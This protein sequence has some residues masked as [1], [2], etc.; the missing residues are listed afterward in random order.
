MSN[1]EFLVNVESYCSAL[2]S[3]DNSIRQQGEKSLKALMTISQPYDM[4]F[5]VLKE[6][7][8]TWA[9]FYMLLGIRDASIKEWAILEPQRKLMIVDTLY[10]YILTLNQMSFVNSATRNQSY[11]TIAVICKRSWLD[12]E[13]YQQGIEMNQLIMERVYQCVDSNDFS[14][15]EAAIQM[16]HQMITEFSNKTNAAK[17]QLSWEY[18]L[19]CLMSFQSL[20]LQPLFRKVMTIVGQLQQVQMNS[21]TLQMLNITLKIFLDILEW[22][23]AEKDFSSLAFISSFS[24]A[25]HSLKP[26]EEWSA[27]FIQKQ[28]D[29]SYRSPVLELV[30]SLY[31][32]FIQLDKIP[33]LLR[34]SLGQ[35]VSL[36]GP[37]VKNI[38]DKN[39]YFSVY[40][41]KFIVVLEKSIQTLNWTEM[42]D[43]AYCIHRLCMNFRFSGFLQMNQPQLL[44]TFLQLIARFVFAALDLMKSTMSSGEEDL[45]SE[46]ELDCLDIVLKGWVALIVDLDSILAKQRQNQFEHFDQ[47]HPVFKQC[48]NEIYQKYIQTRLELSR[49][50]LSKYDQLEPDNDDNNDLN[51]DKNKYNAQLKSV[52]YI[53]R[54]NPT[55]SMDILQNEINKTVQTLKERVGDA[56]CF[57][58]LHWLIIFS[59][60]IVFDSDND[61]LSPIP[62]NVEEESLQQFKV[63]NGQ[64]D[65]I[66]DL[67]NAIIK[68]SMEYE[69]PLLKNNNIDK[70]S[71]LVSKTLVWFFAGWSLVYL[72]PS[73]TLNTQVSPKLLDSFATESNVKQICDFFIQKILWNLRFW[74]AV[75]QDVL[76][77]TCKLYYNLSLNR[78]LIQPMTASP[79]WSMLFYQK[80][81]FFDKLAPEIQYLLHRATVNILYKLPTITEIQTAFKEFT[82][83]LCKNLDSVLSHQNFQSIA[84]EAYVKENLYLILEKLRGVLGVQIDNLDFFSD[85]DKDPSLNLSF[86]LFMKYA[87]SFVAMLSI[88]NH[89]NDII[90]IILTLFSNF[91]KSQ[92][93]T[94]HERAKSA[95][96][97]LINLFQTISKITNSSAGT[98][99]KEYYNRIKVLIKILYNIITYCD[100]QNEYPRLISST[101]FNGITIVTPCLTNKYNLLQYPK[102]ARNYFMVLTFIFN[103]DDISE[104][105]NF[106]VEISNSIFRLVDS[107]LLHHDTEIVKGCFECISGLTKFGKNLQQHKIEFD[108]SILTQYI[109]S[110]INFLLMNEFNIDELLPT[111]SETLFD[112]IISNQQ[113]FKSKVIELI[114]V[115]EASIQQRIIQTFE[116]LSIGDGGRKSKDAFLKQVQNLLLIVKPLLKKQ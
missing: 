96:Q 52:S 60:H 17:I 69:E 107:G 87:N 71:P 46:I 103:S 82:S 86:D 102:L 93:S 24:N 34:T 113:G 53:G 37:V 9:H 22:G 89:N 6:S 61:R 36:T 85:N 19:K 29:G 15:M 54:I 84:Q 104:I 76:K 33:S 18:H 83:G 47:L 8:S 81:Q 77:E 21:L 105:K 13:K 51:E 4:F 39:G 57:E 48:S 98:D 92:I 43:L 11:N 111:A 59:G 42:Q 109:G 88:Y 3:N 26:T 12:S 91:T 49:M 14:Q 58:T 114:T 79:S 95:F 50:E 25:Q 97:C 106:P 32:Q 41:S 101:V 16:I 31:N 23:F 40:I 62:N 110:V 75:D 68:Y 28:Q 55:I 63:T 99:N 72:I 74:G 2:V 56:Q 100:P 115:Q 1:Q 45:E 80:D 44:V 94:D 35:L 116:T 112:L 20:H 90:Q 7:K 78:K 70:L 10:Q 30:F 64:R 38:Q 108:M 73:D 65:S 27:I 66:I 5:Q 67:T